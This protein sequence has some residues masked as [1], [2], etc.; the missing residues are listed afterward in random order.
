MAKKKAVKLHQI[1]VDAILKKIERELRKPDVGD[2]S[3][4]EITL[5]LKGMRMGDVASSQVSICSQSVTNY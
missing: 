3:K 5:D 4:I 1:D 2:V